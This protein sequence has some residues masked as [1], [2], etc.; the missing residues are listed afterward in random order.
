MTLRTW[1]TIGALPVVVIFAGC[2]GEG[3]SGADLEGTDVAVAQQGLCAVS[4]GQSSAV[5]CELTSPGP[6]D[7][8]VQCPHGTSLNIWF[9]AGTGKVAVQHNG[10]ALNAPVCVEGVM[11][12]SMVCKAHEYGD[13]A[14]VNDSPRTIY[15]SDEPFQLEPG[16][17]WGPIIEMQCP[18]EAPFPQWITA[19][20]YIYNNTPYSPG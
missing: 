20:W 2:A 1:R 19:S 6:S 16:G 9:E 11:Q 7:Y 15:V 8:L 10:S 3:A 17:G 13:G 14:V 5:G 4:T 18:P 12:A